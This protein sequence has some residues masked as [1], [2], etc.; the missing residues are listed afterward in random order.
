MFTVIVLTCDDPPTIENAQN[1]TLS[2]GTEVGSQ[3]I[4]ACLPGYEMTGESAIDCQ[5]NQ[6]WSTPP[7][8]QSKLNIVFYAYHF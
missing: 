7:R 4:Y 2:H 1:F 5:T 6:Q 8:C 3:A